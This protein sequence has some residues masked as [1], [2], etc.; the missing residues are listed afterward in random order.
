MVV[1]DE[2]FLFPV[3]GTYLAHHTISV[4]E[5]CKVFL[6]GAA[7]L[8]VSSLPQPFLV[9]IPDHSVSLRRG[10]IVSGAPWLYRSG[11]EVVWLL[12]FSSET[13][14]IRQP[15]DTFNWRKEEA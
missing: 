10:W 1:P 4:D 14:M 8:F 9:G 2:G 13:L 5:H 15:R 11:G 3:L 12:F 6:I 7:Q